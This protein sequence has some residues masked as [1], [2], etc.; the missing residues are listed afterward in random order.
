MML[1][2]D[3]CPTVKLE[4]LEAR[5]LFAMWGP[6]DT[7]IGLDAIRANFPNVTGAGQTIAV[8]DTGIDY[9][10]TALGGGFGAGHKV[11]AGWDFVND[12]EDPMDTF[13]HGTEVASVIAANKFTVD[14]FT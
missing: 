4:G 11:I 5:A 13:G 9:N 1:R 14:G 10:D 8:L 3:A 6:A 7:L 2:R 12:D